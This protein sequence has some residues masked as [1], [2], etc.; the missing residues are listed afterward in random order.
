MKLLRRAPSDGAR[1]QALWSDRLSPPA[2]AIWAG[3]VPLSLA[4]SGAMALRAGFWRLF[5]RKIAGVRVVSIGNLTV[6]GNG[7]TPFA[8]YLARQ[9]RQRGVR[10]AIVSRGF[11]GTRGGGPAFLVADGGKCFLSAQE[12]GDEAVMMA[13]TFAGPIAIAKRRADA[14]ALLQRRG[15]LDVVVLDDAFQHLRLARD[16]NLLL[17][18]GQHGLGNGW[19][20]PAGPMRERLGAA[21][22]ADAVVVLSFDQDNDPPLTARQ[23]VALSRV[24]LLHGSLRPRALVYP[25]AER[26]R[27]E[28]AGSLATRRVLALS[29]VADARNFYAMLRAIDA[30]L[31]GVLEYPDHHGYSAADWREIRRAAAGADLVVTTEKDLVKLERFPFARGELAALRLEVAM[32]DD[33]ERLLALVLDEATRNPAELLAEER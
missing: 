19:V 2:A 14:I 11:G 5:Q 16:L 26:W 32:G 12:A 18:G 23:Q 8:L 22:R 17:I 7:K 31:V 21:A 13:R 30:D 15:P 25:E 29:A 10:T 20:L 24:P 1:L 4:Y 27:E 9:L 6:G 28:P 3:T 33:E